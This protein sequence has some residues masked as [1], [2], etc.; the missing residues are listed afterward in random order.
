MEKSSRMKECEDKWEHCQNEKPSTK[1][2]KIPRGTSSREHNNNSRSQKSTMNELKRKTHDEGWAKRLKDYKL[3]REEDSDGD[4]VYSNG[5]GRGKDLIPCRK[6][7]KKAWKREINEERQ[8]EPE[9]QRTQE[10]R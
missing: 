6:C 7:F 8:M 1:N 2:N 4:S 5:E 9:S 10:G 3:T